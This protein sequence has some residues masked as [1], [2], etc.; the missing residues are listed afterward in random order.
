MED[1]STVARNDGRSADERPL[2]SQ[3][4]RVA[5]TIGVMTGMF[6]AALEATVGGASDIHCCR[7]GVAAR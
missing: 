5:I 6:I 2:I 3:R 1:N 7:R 4:R